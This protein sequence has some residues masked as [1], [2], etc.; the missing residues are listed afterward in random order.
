LLER[1]TPSSW[2]L[3]LIIW[4]TVFMLFRTGDL[5]AAVSQTINRL[6]GL[7]LTI[8][9]VNLFGAVLKRRSPRVSALTIHAS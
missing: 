9:V 5:T 7:A 1:R 8:T 4:V 2:L 6:G 3:H